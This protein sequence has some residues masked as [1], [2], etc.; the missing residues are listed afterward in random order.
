MQVK[1]IKKVITKK[2]EDWLKS[3]TDK[4]LR[5]DVRENLLLTGGSIC[6]LLQGQDV[7]DYDIY[8]QDIDVLARLAEYYTKEFGITILDGRKIDEYRQ[9]LVN[10]ELYIRHLPDVTDDDCDVMM[11]G[12]DGKQ[13]RVTDF[14]QLSVAMRTMKHNQIKLY[15]RRAGGFPT[16][17]QVAKKYKDLGIEIPKYEVAYISPNAISLTDNVQI[18]TRFSGSPEEIHSTFDFIHATNYFTFKD[19]LRF[20]EK[21]LLSIMTKQLYYQGS[22]F[23]LTSVIRVKK[24]L[25]RNWNISAGEQLKMLYQVSEL[26]LNNPDVLEEQLVGVDVAYFSTLVDMLREHDG[27]IDSHII[28]ELIDKVFNE[29]D[30]EE[31]GVKDVVAETE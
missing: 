5:R 26:N 2:L 31:E 16:K 22:Q 24:F 27:D 30:S 3:I 20:N 15:S 14:A 6:S 10:R 18:V 8:I 17:D 19:G 28:C 9:I 1:T 4:D 12:L 25:K 29:Y 13:I 11:E 7:N 21:A 23:P